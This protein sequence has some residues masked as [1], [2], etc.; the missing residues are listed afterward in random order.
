MEEA[1][2]LSARDRRG[3]RG[4]GAPRHTCA[5]DEPGEP[6]ERCQPRQSWPIHSPTRP[7]GEE[8]V[9]DD[10]VGFT[11]GGLAHITRPPGGGEKG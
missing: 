8:G 11:K 10:D 3:R 6:R 2:Q 1:G 9:D 5:R 4:E 7:A